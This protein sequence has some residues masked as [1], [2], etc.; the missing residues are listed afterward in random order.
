M[1][2]QDCWIEAIIVAWQ[3][4]PSPV[5]PATHTGTI[6][7]LTVVFP[8]HNPANMCAKAAEDSPT[9]WALVP[10]RQTQKN[11]VTPALG[12]AKSQ[13]LWPCGEGTKG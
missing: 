9:A 7:G 8:I 5:T 12:P 4:K 6:Q 10:T 11:F 1:A 3:V 13:L 2:S